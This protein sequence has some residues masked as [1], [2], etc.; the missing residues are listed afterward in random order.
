MA[1]T[2][3]KKDESFHSRI[4]KIKDNMLDSRYAK[5]IPRPDS[6]MFLSSLMD[7]G[8]IVAAFILLILTG[9]MTRD[10]S[11][12][13]LAGIEGYTQNIG[14]I[15]ALIIG[16]YVVCTLL[17]SITRNLSFRFLFKTRF[18]F[19][20]ILIHFSTTVVAIVS[21]TLLFI[22]SQQIFQEVASAF[23]NLALLIVAIYWYLVFTS[24]L[25]S[26]RGA[27]ESFRDSVRFKRSF[28]VAATIMVSYFAVLAVGSLLDW[29]LSIFNYTDNPVTDVI[30][31]FL[32]LVFLL[33]GV[34]WARKYV[35]NIIYWKYGAPAKH[36]SKKGKGKR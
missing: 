6:R 24:L 10:I 15:Y 35:S 25:F 9:F 4:A 27:K 29:L 1:R 17:W 22:G 19:N 32:L 21:L 7:F 20:K 36:K 18:S 30:K 13:M 34:S 3:T 2:K 8:L 5:E 26:N 16:A 14:T 12:A 11:A 31:S 28:P 23:V 33:V